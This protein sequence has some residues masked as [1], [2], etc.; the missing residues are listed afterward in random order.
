MIPLIYVLDTYDPKKP[1]KLAQARLNGMNI[2]IN[3][4]EYIRTAADYIRRRFDSYPSIENK[5]FNS[6]D[7]I[8]EATNME[9][10][11]NRYLLSIILFT[12]YFLLRW[13]F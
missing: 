11:F 3:P 2:K 13:C 7:S 9:A 6:N 1:D 5:F 8:S 10:A 4:L 12:I